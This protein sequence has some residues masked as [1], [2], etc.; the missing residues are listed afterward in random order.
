ME[1]SLVNAGV[2]LISGQPASFGPDS[3][4]L[5]VFTDTKPG[6]ELLGDLMFSAFLEMAGGGGGIGATS[7]APRTA[8]ELA[9]GAT[10]AARG[11]V[12]SG[13]DVTEATVQQAMKG[14]ALRTDQGAV[15][16]PAVRRYVDRLAGGETP[17]AIKVDNGV[18]VDGNHRYVAGRVFGQEPPVTPGA[19]PMHKT[20]PG[21]SWDQV[22][23]DPTDW[24]N[25]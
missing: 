11:G 13:A 3:P 16:L 17:P 10:G 21:L 5:R 19:R 15:S 7:R 6:E 2:R 1:K 18:I 9:E 23:V 4:Q 14:A 22:K 20:G 8:T 24:G 25:K 12:T